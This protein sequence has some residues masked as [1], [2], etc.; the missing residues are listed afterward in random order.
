MSPLW[1]PRLREELTPGR[2]RGFERPA[3]ETFFG[4]FLLSFSTD[5][6]S[7]LRVLRLLPYSHRAGEDLVGRA[8]FQGLLPI[9]FLEIFRSS[10]PAISSSLEG[11]VEIFVLG[12]SGVLPF[13]CRLHLLCA[14]LRGSGSFTG[15]SP[16]DF[17][18]PP[19]QPRFLRIRFLPNRPPSQR[20]SSSSFFELLIFCSPLYIARPSISARFQFN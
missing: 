1:T 17:L 10:T 3:G 6:R 13:E 14:F 12:P 20:S 9:F 19:F 2:P 7:F 5:S 18:G 11:T 15:P 4:L 16:L 8:R